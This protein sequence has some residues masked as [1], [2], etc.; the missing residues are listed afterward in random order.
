MRFDRKEE[1]AK[2]NIMKAIAK[3]NRCQLHKLE[4]FEVM[5]FLL[6]KITQLN[7]FG[8]TEYGAEAQTHL[9]WNTHRE[10]KKQKNTKTDTE[11]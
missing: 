6:Q 9:I 10:T 11:R 5:E 8:I 3:A 7:T 1:T 2:N 4:I